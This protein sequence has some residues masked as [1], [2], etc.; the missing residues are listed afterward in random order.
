MHPI[1]PIA[2]VLAQS[3]DR[4]AA[5]RRRADEWRALHRRPDALPDPVEPETVPSVHR[6]RFFGI[7]IGRRTIPAGGS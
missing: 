1:A 3:H 7:V 5:D 2:L 6:R 4:T